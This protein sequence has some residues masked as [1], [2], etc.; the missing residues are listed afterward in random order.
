MSLPLEELIDLSTAV[1]RNRE[2]V[3]AGGGNT[4]VKTRDGKHMY[5]KA[6]GTSLSNM[7]RS[8]G[9][10]R[11]NV[12]KVRDILTDVQLNFLNDQER[13]KKI[14]LKLSEACNDK[15]G[16]E[17]RPS[18]EAH[19][20]AMLGDYVVHLHPISVAAYV[21]SRKGKEL[22]QL[23]FRDE[24]IP[25][26]WVSYVDPG[27]SLAREVY[28]LIQKYKDD[29]GKMPRI[30]FLEKHGLF[31]NASSKQKA[32]DLTYW[33]IDRC[34]KYIKTFPSSFNTSVIQDNESNEKMIKGIYKRVIGKELS[35]AY[36]YDP[37]VSYFLSFQSE[38]CARFFPLTPDEVV[39]SY[40]V[41]IW[42]HHNIT[43]ERLARTVSEYY[44]RN[45][46]VIS[47]ILGLSDGFYIISEEKNLDAIR[48][49]VSVSLRV[50]FNA[51]LFGDIN[52]L[53]LREENFILN[54]ESENFRRE[55]ECM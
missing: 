54:W 4:S 15:F 7:T 27:V 33:V 40:G 23:F 36:S 34:K 22:L 17:T 20:H 6:S 38:Q 32:L 50:R 47:I 37:L 14:V 42:V 18:V 46:K 25:P 45:K 49:M 52:P 3:Q 21:C 26:M 24:D 13:E 44:S 43:E 5:I 39:Y 35:V 12:Q 53:N 1:G 29:I 2:F 10:R 51:K 28:K 30:I 41:G 31:V 55:V 9:W 8:Q 19:I 11:L 16:D 48:E